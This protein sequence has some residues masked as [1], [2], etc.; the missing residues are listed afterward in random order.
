MIINQFHVTLHL[1]KQKKHCSNATYDVI[2]FNNY[3][4]LVLCNQK[5]EAFIPSLITGMYLHFIVRSKHGFRPAT[6]TNYHTHLVALH[7][8]MRGHFQAYD[9]RFTTFNP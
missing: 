4:I 9:E 3:L 8:K 7:I 1:Y 2:S 6:Y 5:I